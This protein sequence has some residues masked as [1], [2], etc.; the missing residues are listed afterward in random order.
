MPT[1]LDDLCHDRDR[2]FDASDCGNI[3]S[4]S[5][6][7]L[8]SCLALLILTTLSLPLFVVGIKCKY[9]DGGIVRKRPIEDDPFGE[10]GMNGITIEAF[11]AGVYSKQGQP[12]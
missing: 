7:L 5:H 8:V 3:E 11:V 12:L 10:A 6:Y 9:F 1:A 4:S 2:C